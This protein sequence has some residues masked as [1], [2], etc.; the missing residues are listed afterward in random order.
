M[1][2]RI[3]KAKE[4]TSIREFYNSIIIRNAGT[5]HDIGWK[6]DQYPSEE[7]L[8]QA[9]ENENLYVGENNSNYVSVMILNDNFCPEYNAVHWN[10]PCEKKETLVIHALAVDPNES[11]K[12]YA[13]QMV[14]FAL[15]SAKKL[16]KKAVRLDV[17]A[18]NHAA[19]QLYLQEGF[20]FIE[21]IQMYYAVTGEKT[22]GMYEYTIC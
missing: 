16:Q 2:I 12:G 6:V 15:D 20:R 13:K 8:Q 1:K 9:L 18:G 19:E 7:V 4:K 17:I 5:I 10:V 3:A 11:G 21:N 22:F 14:R